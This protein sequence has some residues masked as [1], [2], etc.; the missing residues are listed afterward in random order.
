M[1]LDAALQRGIA[2]RLVIDDS[3]VTSEM[4]GVPVIKSKAAAWTIL[5]SFEF[6]VAIGEN[7]TRER[8]FNELVARDGTPT[9]VTHPSAVVSSHALIGRGVVFCAGSVVN[10]CAE[11]GDNVIVNTN[12]SVDHD[13]RISNHVHICPGVHLAGNVTVGARSLIGIGAVVLPGVKIGADCVIGAGSIV[14]RN[15][16]DGVIAFG[17]PAAA[18]GAT[19]LVEAEDRRTED[20]GAEG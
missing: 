20:G 19:K 3:P 17:T 16:A 10:P 2:V 1:V 18:R 15:V 14:T 8:I 6:I 12:A 11:I 13:C 9:N 4:F 5:L 7:L